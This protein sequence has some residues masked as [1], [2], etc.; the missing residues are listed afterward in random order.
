MHT[1]G[2]IR[3]AT[4]YSYTSARR[5]ALSDLPVHLRSSQAMSTHRGISESLLGAALFGGP[6]DSPDSLLPDA[7]LALLFRE[8][9]TPR[10]RQA[11]FRTCRGGRR[12]VL[13]TAPMVSLR[14]R[15]PTIRSEAQAPASGAALS[16]GQRLAAITARYRAGELARRAPRADNAARLEAARAALL[17]RGTQ[18][19][20]LLLDCSCSYNESLNLSAVVDTLLS[21]AGQCITALQLRG[22]CHLYSPENTETSIAVTAFL[23]SAAPHLPSLASLTLNFCPCILPS[24]A[25]LP[26]LRRLCVETG[27]HDDE[28]TAAMYR[29]ITPYLPQ[30]T[31][32]AVSDDEHALPWDELFNGLKTA[33]AL[34]HFTTSAGL[35]QG[36]ARLLL[37]HCPVLQHV[38]V[39]SVYLGGRDAG[40]G[41]DSENSGD[42]EWCVETLTLTRCS[43]GL[44]DMLAY[45]PRRAGAGK[46]TV[47]WG[48]RG[49]APLDI[50]VRRPEVPHTHTHTHTHTQCVHTRALT[51]AYTHTHTQTAGLPHTAIC[52]YT[53]IH[54]Q[55][56]LWLMMGSSLPKHLVIIFL[57]CVCA[58]PCVQGLSQAVLQRLPD[59][60]LHSR[61]VTVSPDRSLS[62]DS[63]AAALCAVLGQLNSLQIQGT[64]PEFKGWRLPAGAVLSQLSV[65]PNYDFKLSLD[66]PLTDWALSWAVQAAPHMHGLSVSGLTLQ[67]DHYSDIPWL[68]KELTVQGVRMLD[69]VKMPRTKGRVRAVKGQQIILTPRVAQVS[70]AYHVVVHSFTVLVLSCVYIRYP[71]TASMCLSCFGFPLMQIAVLEDVFLYVYACVAAAYALVLCRTHDSQ[72]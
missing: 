59:C 1:T 72:G 67:T 46:L 62:A 6:E 10:M 29:T 24:P 18:P 17:V 44:V 42:G 7:W 61:S 47:V 8:H 43:H 54:T 41:R 3:G 19:T 68:W 70:V 2:S 28:A 20:T 21:E 58:F 51:H 25:A 48:T 4:R 12:L 50:S 33:A 30:L 66:G 49:Y 13:Q 9:A 22:S 38:S 45:L 60:I 71:S 23:A 16:L 65:A 35:C 52:T 40:G 34:T 55:T 39:E 53:H 15:A 27:S 56:S 69:L 32:L 26:L 63:H 31:G 11:V 36:L 5:Q 14:L 57:V 37:K 64:T